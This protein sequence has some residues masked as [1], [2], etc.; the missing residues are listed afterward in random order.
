MPRT[1]A[2]TDCER[3][4]IF[5]VTLL[6]MPRVHPSDRCVNDARV[7]DVSVRLLACPAF[8]CVRV[9]CVRRWGDREL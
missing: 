6:A 9:R 7:C 4:C 8:V 5:G 1:D 2:R 3:P